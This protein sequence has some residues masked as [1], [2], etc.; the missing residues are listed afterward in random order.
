[1]ARTRLM[2]SLLNLVEDVRR[3]EETGRSL[4]EVRASRRSGVSRRDFL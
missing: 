3:S 4:E 1:M 2:S